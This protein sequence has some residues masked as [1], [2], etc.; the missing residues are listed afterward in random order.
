M[1][2]GITDRSGSSRGGGSGHDPLT[3]VYELL[4]CTGMRKGEAL[5]LHEADERSVVEDGVISSRCRW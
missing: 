4:I 1:P 5:G 3:E 2:V